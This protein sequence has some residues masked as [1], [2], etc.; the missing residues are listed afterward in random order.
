MAT[1]HNKG[2][3]AGLAW[4]REN[5]NHRGDSCLT[6]PLSTD[7]KG[8]GIVG[9]NGKVR[10]SHRIMCELVNGPP[11]GL[12]YEAAHSCGRGHK[13]C[14][15][16]RHLFWKTRSENQRDRRIHG[17]QGK[18]GVS[19]R[20]KMTPEQISEVRSIGNRMTQK[21]LARQFN[22]TPSNIS[23]ILSGARWQKTPVWLKNNLRIADLEAIKTAKGSKT[24]AELA[25]EYGVSSSVIW[26]IQS[27]RKYNHIRTRD[28]LAENGES[29]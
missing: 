13:A 19:A 3:G 8:Y 14:C 29:K 5:A 16:P 24:R 22:C 21:A 15:N 9:I 6:W 11:P 23:K 10:K 25:A 18:P 7:D 4:I 1:A 12:K 2:K 28:S 20:S 17:T 26:R 27:G